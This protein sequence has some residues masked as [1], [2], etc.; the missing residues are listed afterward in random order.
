MQCEKSKLEAGHVQ[1][2]DCI[3]RTRVS[4]QVGGFS[5]CGCINVR[6]DIDGLLSDMHCVGIA[7]WA[8]TCLVKVNFM[9]RVFIQ[10]L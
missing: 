1:T 9:G 10:E 3:R 5:R 4:M 2:A 7:S 8:V 6:V